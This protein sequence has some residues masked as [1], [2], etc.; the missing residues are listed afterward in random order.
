M[1]DVQTEIKL[2]SEFI[3]FQFLETISKAKKE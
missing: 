3:E 2:K 1:N